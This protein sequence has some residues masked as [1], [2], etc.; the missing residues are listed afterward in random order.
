VVCSWAF[1]PLGNY[2]Q[3]GDMPGDLC[4]VPQVFDLRARIED[5]GNRADG[6]KFSPIAGINPATTAVYVLNDTA[7]PLVVDVDG[8]GVCDAINPNLVPTTK[9]PARSN[10]VLA[11]RLSAVPPKGVADFTPDPSLTNPAVQAAYPACA[12]GI[13]VLGPRPLCGS[14]TLSV[15]I[16]YPAARGPNPAIWALEPITG[17]EPWC[18]G[19]QFDTFANEIPDGWA[20]LAA[21][22]ADF[23]GN[24]SVSSPLR[25]WVQHKGLPNGATC[26][27][28][29][30]NAGAPPNCTGSYNRQTGAV[31]TTPC[32]G[33][34]FPAR[35][36]INEGA[37][38][39]GPGL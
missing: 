39:E 37:L 34:S 35:E 8:D 29:P 24:S 1:N 26:P 18:V 21:G 28:A 4:A 25:V 16:G 15:V 27:G 2:R 17:G 9:A 22:A 32:R 33:R 30:P 11:V 38:P 12:P 19:S 3:L 5:D 7:Q 36:T 10:E 31:S 23:L 6:L 20:C 14:Q 13:E